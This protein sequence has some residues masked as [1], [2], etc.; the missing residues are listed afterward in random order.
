LKVS[1]ET[2][3]DQLALIGERLC[4]FWHFDFEPAVAAARVAVEVRKLGLG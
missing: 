1:H 4:L 3:D 2:D